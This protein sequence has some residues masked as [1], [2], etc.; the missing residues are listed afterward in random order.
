MLAC[1]GVRLAF[2][3]LQATQARA[4]FSQVVW[5]PWERGMT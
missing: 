3:A 1:S 4:Q 5:P 2:R